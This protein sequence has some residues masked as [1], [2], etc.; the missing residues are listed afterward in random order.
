MKTP[1]SN[2]QPNL[3]I[4][5]ILMAIIPKVV[6]A[7]PSITAVTGPLQNGQM[8]TLSGTGFGAKS[9]AVP[10]KWDD[11]E[12]GTTGNNIGNSSPLGVDV[13]AWILSSQGA[14]GHEPKYSTTHSHS[15]FKAALSD[16]TGG[17]YSSQIG[18][19]WSSNRQGVIYITWW[20]YR[21]QNP[22]NSI[23]NWKPW[24]EYPSWGENGSFTGCG[25]NNVYY[26]SSLCTT[27]TMTESG[28]FSNNYP[29][30]VWQLPDSTWERWEVL[31]STGTPGNSD[32]FI[33]YR[34]NGVLKKSIIN[35]AMLEGGSTGGWKNTRVNNYW[36]GRQGTLQSWIDDLYIDTT[37]QRVEV[38]DASVWSNRNHCEIQI[39]SS[40]SDSSITI[41]FN[42]GS[43]ET[44]RCLYLYVVDVNGNITNG[45]PIGNCSTY[46]APNPPSGLTILD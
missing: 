7:S 26:P 6:V 10:Q 24:R 42:Q 46:G 44:G 2:I 1:L 22:T 35:I 19:N 21:V 43:F 12:S 13:S 28:V 9:P 17:C 27:D 8:I 31:Y 45:F 5:L 36:D 32:G 11:F 39:P 25:Y 18:Y 3:L 34:I 33:E 20:L 38:C 40:W 29:G 41:T 16:N 30:I 37:Q 4:L 14:S 15:G 23:Y